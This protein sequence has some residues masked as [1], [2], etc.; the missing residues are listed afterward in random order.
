M[1]VCVC[2]CMCVSMW[3]CNY[4]HRYTEIFPSSVHW[5]C[6]RGATPTVTDTHYSQI[7]ASKYH[8]LFKETRNS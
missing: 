4:V 7:L 1:Y 2:V 6:W 8:S 3:M 5:G